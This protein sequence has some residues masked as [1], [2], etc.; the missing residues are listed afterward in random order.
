V[1]RTEDV[2]VIGAGVIGAAIA[3]ELSRRG[4]W[5]RLLEAGPTSGAATLASAGILAPFVEAGADTPLETLGAESLDFYDELIASLRQ[6]TRCEIDYTRSGTLEVALDV[7]AARRLEDRAAAL[8]AR[9]ISSELVDPSSIE[10][11][12][13]SHCLQGLLIRR[14]GAVNA[15]ALAAAL[16]NA[17]RRRGALVDTGVR[18]ELVRPGEGLVQVVTDRGA[19]GASH[20]VL[21]CGCWSGAVAIGDEPRLP[22][23]PI[24]GQLLQLRVPGVHLDHVVW[25]PNCYLVP[26]E[27]GSVLVG[28]TVEDAGFDPRATVAGVQSL[29]NA[30]LALVPA[31]DSATFDA[32]RV[33]L[34]PATPDHLPIVGLSRVPGVLYATGHYRNGILLAPLTARMIADLIVEGRSHPALA[35]LAPSR[36]DHVTTVGNS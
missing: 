6:D 20:V 25:G 5:V 15:P 29:L 26:R 11:P 33:G 30:A 13:G 18:A 32:V 36:F 12:L 1:G 31:L 17:S 35:L 3:Y 14:H 24:R 28:A 8:Q 27:D 16:L 21:A 4:V 22:V 10:R 34:R 9:G 19:F 2:I 7:S 23:W